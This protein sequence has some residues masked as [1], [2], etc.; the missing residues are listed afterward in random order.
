MT[1]KKTDKKM[2]LVTSLELAIRKE[3]RADHTPTNLSAKAKPLLISF[4]NSINNKDEFDLEMTKMA[5]KYM[6]QCVKKMPPGFGA[7]LIF[8]CYQGI[9][10]PIVKQ[11]F[12]NYL[13]SKYLNVSQEVKT[14]LNNLLKNNTA[15][16]HACLISSRKHFL[17]SVIGRGPVEAQ[18]VLGD[19]I[20]ELESHY[21]DLKGDIL[22]TRILEDLK[23]ALHQ[24]K[25]RSD[26]EQIVRDFR[27]SHKYTLLSAKQ[28]IGQ[29]ETDS[30]EAF[31]RI[32]TDLRINVR[33]NKNNKVIS[34]ESAYTLGN[35]SE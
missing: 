31:K 13:N 24:A 3:V 19:K 34:N 8:D 11:E 9:K 25:K 14:N 23:N 21:H 16:K 33:L 35:Q 7:K 2:S 1:Y 22:K 32:V 17:G 28:G 30:I 18:K 15:Y 27:A 5:V 26:R 20:H 6:S 29:K 4:L 10:D 12:V